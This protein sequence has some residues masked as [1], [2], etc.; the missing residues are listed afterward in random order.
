MNFLKNIFARIWAAWGLLT[1]AITFLIFFLPSMIAYA[2]PDP[3]GQSYFIGLAR[4][5]M[6][7]WLF[8][9]GC[10][11]KITGRNNFEKGK[12]YVVVFNH[13]AFLDVPLSAPF[14]PGPNKTI[15]KATFAKIPLFGWY[16]KKGS[17]LVN[18]NDDRSRQK[19]FEEMKKVLLTGMH[20]CIYPEGT[21][22]RTDQPLKSFYDG[23]FKL[24]ISTQ[25]EIIPCIIKG[26]K[27]AMPIHKSF[28][29]LPT[30]LSMHFLPP[31]TPGNDVKELKERVYKRMLGEVGSQYSVVRSQ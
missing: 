6:R 5:W 24:A 9:I 18:R 13:N 11:L 30:K 27:R 8:L 10:P 28:Y 3:G 31:E 17:V 14:I 21:R 12:T 2:M 4:V 26:T 22:N 23:A 1:F 15:A 25:K 19:S 7:L 16:Y 29:L 20:M